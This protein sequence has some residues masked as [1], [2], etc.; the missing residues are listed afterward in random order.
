MAAR[1]ATT[2]HFPLRGESEPIASKPLEDANIPSYTPFKTLNSVDADGE[3]LRPG[4][5]YTIYNT[6]DILGTLPD[7][8][9]L[10]I[11]AAARWAGV[12]PVYVSGVVE[13]LER[14]TARWWDVLRRKERD[15]AAAEQRRGS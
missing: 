15:E 5:Q 2:D 6:Q 7:D 9:D 10:I 12:E 3:E 1:N 13:R 4:E 11:S 8:L 14:R